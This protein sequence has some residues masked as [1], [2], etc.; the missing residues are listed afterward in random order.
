MK[1]GGG[2]EMH[3]FFFF[4]TDRQIGKFVYKGSILVQSL[5][6]SHK[7]YIVVCTIALIH[8]LSN[9]NEPYFPSNGLILKLGSSIY[10]IPQD[11]YY[12][13]LKLV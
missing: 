1:M 6:N 9:K 8:S 12:K 4:C 10:P 3:L 7:Q 11:H 2:L 13:L 5:R